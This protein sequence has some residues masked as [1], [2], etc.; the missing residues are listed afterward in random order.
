MLLLSI[1]SLFIGPILY[2]WMRR[3]GFVAKAFDSLIITV[4]ILL[5][6]FFL[7]PESWAELG[8]WSV[9]LILTGYL[10]PGLLEQLIKKAAHTLHL[11]SLLLALTGLALHAMLDGAALNAGDGAMASNLSMAI[12]IHRFGVGMMIWMMVQPVFGRQIAFGVLGF[13]SLATVGGYLLS[14]K[15]M[16]LEGDY[17]TSVIQAL[18]IGMIVHSLIHRSHG[19][20]HHH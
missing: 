3:G 4:L 6:A 1:V 11:L 16:G 9:G 18:I 10:A 12:V 20:S 19:T 2:Q 14:E 17:A 15:L 7:I 5:M 8:Y 13:A